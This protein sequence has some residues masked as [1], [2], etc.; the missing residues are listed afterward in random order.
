MPRL[1]PAGATLVACAVFFLLAPSAAGATGAWAAAGGASTIQLTQDQG[2]PGT[3]VVVSGRYGGPG[4]AHEAVLVSFTEG[5]REATVGR[6]TTNPDYRLV[7]S[8]PQWA[9]PGHA[10]LSASFESPSC[11]GVASGCFQT[12]VR[13]SFTVLAPGTPVSSPAV[14]VGAVPS[15]VPAGSGGNEPR[16]AGRAWPLALAVVGALLAGAGL[17]G[18]RRTG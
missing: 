7:V 2:H 11:V 8:V 3:P 14:A 4:T 10:Q 17:L 6:G 1:R 15:A 13:A 9:S 18:A 5:K 12:L 16:P